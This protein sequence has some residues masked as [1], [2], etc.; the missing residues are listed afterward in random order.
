[1]ELEGVSLSCS[2]EPPLIPVLSQM[3]PVHIVTLYSS[4]ILFNIVL[5]SSFQGFRL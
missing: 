4:K 2:Q 5:V 3:N 1:M